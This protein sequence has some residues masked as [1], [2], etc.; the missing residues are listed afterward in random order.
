MANKSNYDI[1][2]F[3]KHFLTEARKVLSNGIK[4]LSHI[5]MAF[6]NKAS[7]KTS[8]GV[9]IVSKIPLKVLDVVK[10][11]TCTMESVL[12]KKEQHF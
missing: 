12:L 8:S 9:F 6:N 7:L 10:Y 1:I 4:K 3:Q 2:V 5:N 11:K